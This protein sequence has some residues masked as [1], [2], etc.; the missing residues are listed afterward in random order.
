MNIKERPT[1]ITA[2]WRLKYMLEYLI[3][4]VLAQFITYMIFSWKPDEMDW[5]LLI[6][7]CSCSSGILFIVWFFSSFL[8]SSFLGPFLSLSFWLNII[9]LLSIMTNGMY[10][11]HQAASS[12]LD[13]TV[14][15]LAFYGELL[16]RPKIPQ[17]KS[18]N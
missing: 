4:I 14:I 11:S 9:F 8:P 1:T 15:P 7:C 10:S 2:K 3:V 16:N 12:M 13:M 17:T 18:I 6:Y 5:V